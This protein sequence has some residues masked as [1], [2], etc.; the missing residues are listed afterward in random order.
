MV[1]ANFEKE[2]EAKCQREGTLT[3][4]IERLLHESFRQKRA[5]IDTVDAKTCLKRS[6][7]NH[8]LVGNAKVLRELVLD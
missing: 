6:Q 8:N 7:G 1:S 3:N 2:F 4:E 5:A